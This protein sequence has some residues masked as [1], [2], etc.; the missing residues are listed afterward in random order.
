MLDSSNQV[1]SQNFKHEL[2]L[3]DTVA[4]SFPVNKDRVN[5]ASIVYSDKVQVPFQLNTHTDKATLSIAIQAI[6]Y[7]GGDSKV[8]QGISSVKSSIFDKSGRPGVPKVVVVVMATKSKDDLVVPTTI[9][10]AEGVKLI[11]VGVGKDVDA[12]LLG[13][14]ASSPDSVLLLDKMDELP[15][16]A[17]PI[18]VK[19]NN[20]KSFKELLY[21]F[22]A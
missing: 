9:L 6:P 15:P 11:M 17:A 2:R 3:F 20:G 10:K 18:V 22:C 16:Q 5:F 21:T 12:S 1:G 14:V 19:I 4:Q 13:S 7:I 8:G